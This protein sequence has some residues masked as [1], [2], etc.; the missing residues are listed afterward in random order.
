MTNSTL[1]NEKLVI[2]NRLIKESTLTLE[3]AMLLLKEDS[4]YTTTMP[5]NPLNTPGITLVTPNPFHNPFQGGHPHQANLSVALHG[6]ANST[7]VSNSE[8]VLSGGTDTARGVT[9]KKPELFTLT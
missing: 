9:I 6:S 3:E 5:F 7:S 2:L 1:Y 8:A 4:P